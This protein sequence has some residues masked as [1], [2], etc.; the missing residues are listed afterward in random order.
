MSE[1]GQGDRLVRH[2]VLLLAMAQ[3]A[4][5]ADEIGRAAEPADAEAAQADA[6][7][8]AP[9]TKRSKGK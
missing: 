1:T 4:N 6:P 7:E 8:D 5:L 9:A 2:G 3:V